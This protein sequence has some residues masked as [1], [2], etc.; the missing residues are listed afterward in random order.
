M[1]KGE[2]LAP[3][4]SPVVSTAKS[5]SFV[6]SWSL[7]LDRA[8][9]ITK[10]RMYIGSHIPSNTLFGTQA[11]ER[12]LDLVKVDI[13]PPSALALA[14][15]LRALC[16]RANGGAGRFFRLA[17]GRRALEGGLGRGRRGG[18]HAGWTRESRGAR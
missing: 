9:T 16:G 2:I 3:C 5:C 4:S 7:D 8:S 17:R 6:C 14:A 18:R 11:L 15:R 13:L 10:R 12:L 1:K